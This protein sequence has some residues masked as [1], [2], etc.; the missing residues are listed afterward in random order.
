MR[1]ALSSR[2]DLA[3]ADAGK[4]SH[5]WRRRPATRTGSVS[6]AHADADGECGEVDTCVGDNSTDTDVD[7]APGARDTVCPEDPTNDADGDGI[8]ETDDNCAGV[9]N[10]EQTDDDG[11]AI[12]D[13]CEPDS[14][15]DGVVDDEDNCA[16]GQRR[17]GGH[18]RRRRRER[19]LLRHALRTGAPS[20]TRRRGCA[21]PRANRS[22]SFGGSGCGQ[23]AR[24][25]P[26]SSAREARRGGRARPGPHHTRE[27]ERRRRDSRWATR[28]GIRWPDR[29]RRPCRCP[30]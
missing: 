22:S 17:P 14:D 16:P 25:L 7:D 27:L 20:G 2:P 1:R 26:L 28:A 4:D 11:D 12:G 30:P 21:V 29:R 13:A 9:A 15:G 6:D 23:T 24:G 5:R 19:L 8:C 18:R 10:P 3:L